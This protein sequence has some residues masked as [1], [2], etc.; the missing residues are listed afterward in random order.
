MLLLADA[1][2]DRSYCCFRVC[3]SET[4]FLGQDQV[5]LQRSDSSSKTNKKFELDLTVS[6]VYSI[7][8]MMVVF[9]CISV[10]C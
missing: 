8:T 5:S 7:D 6:L 3:S 10:A 4:L 2:Y 9:H 1:K